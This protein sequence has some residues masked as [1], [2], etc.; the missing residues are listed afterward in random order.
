MTN[1]RDRSKSMG[2]TD[3]KI[4]MDGVAEKIHQLWL[5]K[6]GQA[7]P[8]DLS[9][10][11]PVRRGQATEALNIEWFERKTQMP[12]SRRGDVVRHPLLPWATVTL[13]G[14]VK[15]IE[16]PLEAKDVGGHEPLEVVIMRYQPQMQWQCEVTGANQVA[17]SLII[18]AREP[19]VDYIA[20]DAEYADKMIEVGE[21][22]WKHVVDR[23]PPVDLP[24]VPPPIEAKALYDMTGDNRWASEAAIWLET[25]AS[26]EKNEAAALMLKELVPADAKK[27]TGH[28]VFISRNRVGNLSLRELK[29]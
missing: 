17:L 20:R 15:A 25:K 3:M 6:T 22:F 16:C 21:L 29:K 19:V 1:T 4:I 7:D 9:G 11:W 2:G 24:V 5:E 10:V 12:V 13:D 28:G 18:G 14:W 23:T 27:C 8:P 26:V